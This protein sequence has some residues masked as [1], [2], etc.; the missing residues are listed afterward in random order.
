[1]CEICGR[2]L[3]SVFIS[4]LLFI[5]IMVTL[6]NR[7]NQLCVP[8]MFHIVSLMFMYLHVFVVHKHVC[9]WTCCVFMLH[10]NLNTFEIPHVESLKSSHESFSVLQIKT[11]LLKFKASA[12]RPLIFSPN[13]LH[14]GQR[15]RR[16]L[17]LL[18]CWNPIMPCKGHQT[19][20]QMEFK[21]PSASLYVAYEYLYLSLSSPPPPSVLIYGCAAEAQALLCVCRDGC[22]ARAGSLHRS[23]TRRDGYFSWGTP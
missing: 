5:F 9:V 13:V 21:P 4:C 14:Q 3:S 1:M 11:K 12:P 19:T 17:C 23:L 8:L 2:C 18:A 16:R 10:L 15:S 22:A 6:C 7:L 20:L